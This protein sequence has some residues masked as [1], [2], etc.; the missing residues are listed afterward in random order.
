MRAFTGGALAVL[1]L[2]GLPGCGD[3]PCEIHATIELRVELVD[4]EGSPLTPSEFMAKFDA[5]KIFAC[6]DEPE[7]GC[8]EVGSLE[9]SASSDDSAL[10]YQA[11]HAAF[12]KRPLRC[13]YPVV[14]VRIDIPGCDSAVYSTP[15][16]K[17][18]EAITVSDSLTITCR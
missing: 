18:K 16:G 11:D 9:L 2:V 3:D 7:S 5:A 12:Q 4:A 8:S 14:E 10:S 15:G 13:E 6:K 17:A 1:A